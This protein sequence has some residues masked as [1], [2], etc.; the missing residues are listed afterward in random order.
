MPRLECRLL[1][2]YQGFQAVQVTP[3]RRLLQLHQ[4][5]QE[6]QENLCRGPLHACLSAS[7]ST[8]IC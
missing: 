8:N 2:E 7:V 5:G 3:V 6:V 4:A 1:L